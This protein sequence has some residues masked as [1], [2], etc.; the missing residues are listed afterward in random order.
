MLKVGTSILH[1]LTLIYC[2]LL[3]QLHAGYFYCQGNLL[4]LLVLV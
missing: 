2:S 1:L 4:I 3:S